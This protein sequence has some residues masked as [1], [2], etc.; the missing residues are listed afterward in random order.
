[1][2]V[3][4]LL[5]ALGAAGIALATC[6]ADRSA[7]L[8]EPRKAVSTHPPGYSALLKSVT[9]EGILEHERRFETIAEANGDTRAAGTP[10]YRGSREYVAQRLRRA[11]YSVRIQSFEFPYFRVLA[12]PEMARVSPNPRAYELGE[13]FAPMKYSGSGQVSAELEPVD[14]SLPPSGEP[15]PSTSGCE[16]ADFTGFDEGDVALLRRGGC[17]FAEKAKNAEA[18]GASTTVI[19]NGGEEGRTR[20][21]RSTL[22]GPGVAIP[23]F[24]ASFAL[25][26]DLVRMAQRGDVTIRIFA[27][28]VVEVR[29][30]SNVIADTE[31]G[32]EDRTVVVGA[33]LDSVQHG[34]G[35]ND[36]GSGSATVLEVAE[37]MSALG[38]EPRN[39]VRFAFWGAEELGLWGSKHY[40]AQLGE[41]QLGDIAVYLN[42]DML[43]S[44]NYARFVYGSREVR[45]VFDDYFATRDLKTETLDLE[46]G[47]DH[48]PFAAEGIS[49]GGL[50]SGAG[51]KKTEEQAEVYGGEAG[52]AYDECYHE[53]CDDLDNLSK[54]ALEQL[55]DGVA[56]ATYVLAQEER[57]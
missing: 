1:L 21:I 17:A 2:G 10:G 34:P 8:P 20:T 53:D 44:P 42:F 5:A 37:K 3:L 6:S 23:V 56:Y 7:Q 35:I 49:V 33:H 12:P 51:G 13:D 52:V 15:K 16:E 47:S 36:N 54:E 27:S 40:V 24:G 18:A 32:R 43:A 4:V 9:P 57:W 28:T 11:G 39:R 46:G 30:A 14:T 50:F 38:V 45:E 19:F 26:E 25:G 48:V 22:G 31:G 41:R 29:E 55:S